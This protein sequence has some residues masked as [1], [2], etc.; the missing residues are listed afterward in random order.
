ML[1][2]TFWEED[3]WEYKSKRK[4]KPVHPNIS[5]S[6]EK[7]TDGKYQTKRKGNKKRT[8]EDKGT[9]KD[10]KVCLGETN[11]Q[12]SV[13]SSQNSSCRD[14]IQQSQSKDTTPRKH[15]RAHRSK[16]LSP[17]VRPVYEG[18]CP[19]CQVPFSSLLGQTP[20]WHVF[21]CLDSPPV[22]NIEC[23]EGLLC[24]STIPSHYKK[25]THLLLAQGRASKEPVHSPSHVPA[26]RLTAA[27]PDSCDLEERLPVHLRTE[28]LR[29]VLDDSLSMV[30]CLRTSQPPAETNKKISSSACSQMS[31]VTECAE[32]VKKD[33]LWEDGLPPVE[34]TLK[35]QSNSQGPSL[36]ESDY[37]ISYSPLQSDEETHDKDTEL[38]DSQQELFFTQSSEDSSLENGSAIFEQLHHSFP[39][40]PEGV[41]PSVESLWTQAEFRGSGKGRALNDSFQLI[42]QTQGRLAQDDGAHTGSGFLL[43]SHA[44]AVGRAASNCQTTKARPEEPEFHSL[45]SSHQKQKIETSAVGNQ[46]SLPLLTST[47]AKPLEKEE[48]ECRSVNPTQSQ[49]KGSQRKGMDAAGANSTCACRKVEKC[50]STPLAKSVSSSPVS[51]SYNAS[52]PAKK[53][54]RQ[55]D[56]GVF[57]GLPPKRQE[58]TSPRKSA[59]ERPNVSPIV[60][61]KEKRPR[62]GKRKAENSVS[63]LEFDARNLNESLCPTELSGETAQHRRKRPRKS[64]SLRE[65]MYQ[66]SG[67]LLTSPEMGTASLS[68]GKASVR[69]THGR[70]QRGNVAISESA[71]TGKLQRS[72]PFYKRIPGTGFT[73]DAFQ[74]GEVEGCT[75]YFLTHFHSDHYAGLSKDFTMPVYCSEITGNLLKKK[76]HVQAQYVHQL[77]M[78]TECIVDGVKVVLLDANHCP[79]ATMILFQLANGAVLLHTGDFRADPSMERSVLAGRKVHT[80]YLDT[81]YCSPEY[82]FPSQQEV[83]Q[84][85]IN[86][87]FE[88]VTLNPRALVVC[89]TY[90]IGKEKVF[91][92][93]ADVLGSK[94]GMSQEK[95]KT[96]QCLNIPEISS[97][98]TTDMCNSSVHLLPMTQVNFKGLQSHLKKCGGKYDQILA[99]RPTGW[100]HSNNITSI[101]GITPQMKGNISIYGIPYSEHSSYLEMKRFVQWLKPQKII[102]TVN[103][104]TFKS[105][106]TMEKYFKEWRLEAGY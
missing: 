59:L 53:V 50:S 8:K 19:S 37:E 84:F 25:Y 22:S 78:D 7:A 46:I 66:R 81:T 55:M 92:A 96:L 102:P 67:P 93:I 20:R 69:W 35:S 62:L 60:S 5:E 45:G 98:I 65:G 1:E 31:V 23:P 99:F 75:A 52:Q 72:C 16:Q 70:P 89:G 54:M 83:I 97:L 11:S 80:L 87:A 36:P 38:D 77:P 79:G 12:I 47:M 42:S 68:R 27:K 88:A 6:V 30:Q 33:K 76:L 73:V 3:I 26:A 58:E 49:S 9:P 106:S 91:L 41:C 10:H 48:G 34:D 56:I 15:R 64:S 74:Y 14:E 63:D 40:E 95:Y 105:R 18:Y 90:C 57:F 43:F 44:L 28:N 32:F 61:P 100:T 71:G 85:A 104:G 2:D 13:G 94:V 4:P 24:S 17:R 29:K 86:T 51:P 82:T 39:K 103:V 21:E 101:A